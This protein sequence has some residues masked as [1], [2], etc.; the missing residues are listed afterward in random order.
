MSTHYTNYVTIM[1][2]TY[3]VGMTKKQAEKIIHTNVFVG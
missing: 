3:E 1:N 2:G